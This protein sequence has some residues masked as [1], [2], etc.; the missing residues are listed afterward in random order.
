VDF[1]RCTDTAKV[2]WG[3]YKINFRKKVLMETLSKICYG[4]NYGANKKDL[5]KYIASLSLSE[6]GKRGS[7]PRPSAW[8]A[9]IDK[10]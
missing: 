10:L 6:S 9:D 2:F 4:A 5:Q 8:E 1:L 7:N 3:N